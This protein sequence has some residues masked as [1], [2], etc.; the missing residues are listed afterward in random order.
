MYQHTYM[1]NVCRIWVKTILFFLYFEVFYGKR[2]K[3]QHMTFFVVTWKL[4]VIN[5]SLFRKIA[6]CWKCLCC[7]SILIKF[8]LQTLSNISNHWHNT[9]WVAPKNNTKLNLKKTKLLYPITLGWWYLPISISLKSFLWGRSNFEYSCGRHKSFRFPS[10]QDTTEFCMCWVWRASATKVDFITSPIK[11]KKNRL[12]IC[13]NTFI[14]AIVCF[15]KIR[16]SMSVY[17]ERIDIIQAVIKL[18]AK[19]WLWFYSHDLIFLH[20]S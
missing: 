18:K 5:I 2:R 9:R 13:F 17:D 1:L 4:I 7:N 20:P 16:K 11:D 6:T 8:Y 10:S 19:F 3:E 14:I 15:Y 12:I